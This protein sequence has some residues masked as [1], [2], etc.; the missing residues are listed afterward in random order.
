MGNYIKNSHIQPGCRGE[1][2]TS[3]VN[4]FMSVVLPLF[5][6][7]AL[8]F[9]VTGAQAQQAAEAPSAGISLNPAQ[10]GENMPPGQLGQ[11]GQ[12]GFDSGQL[13]GVPEQRGGFSEVLFKMM[14]MFA[15][16][17]LIFYFMVIK[18]QQQ[19]LK[20][21]Q[22]LLKSLKKGDTVVTTGGIVARFSG[23]EGDI[24]VLEL[25]PNVKARFELSHVSRLYDPKKPGV[26]DASPATKDGEKSD[27]RKP[28]A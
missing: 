16:V 3:A 1:V 20:D 26:A 9:G 13:G 7:F 11:A 14:P 22:G 24:A 25:S 12:G 19:K 4:T 8:F 28:A 27:K 15:M 6:T 18:P 5:L 21:Q 10:F 17:F 2:Q 23:I